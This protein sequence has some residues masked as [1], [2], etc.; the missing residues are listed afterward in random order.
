MS[1][2]RSIR[3]I[4]RLVK[5]HGETRTLREA[6][7]CSDIL[8]EFLN[9]KQVS[10]ITAFAM[11]DDIMVDIDSSSL[12]EEKKAQ[13]K[14]SIVLKSEVAQ[15]MGNGSF[16]K[17]LA[18][19][20]NIDTL[21][22]FCSKN[23]FF[24]AGEATQVNKIKDLD[25][26]KGHL[27]PA[28]AY[29]TV[30]GVFPDIET[31]VVQADLARMINSIVSVKRVTNNHTWISVCLGNKEEAR[32]LIQKG[33]VWYLGRKCNVFMPSV[34][35]TH[36][37]KCLKQGHKATE[38]K[39]ALICVRCLCAGHKQVDCIADVTCKSCGEAH[40]TKSL[41]CK[42]PTHA[43]IAKP[44]GARP[45]PIERKQENMPRAVE[46]KGTDSASST[47]WA[48]VVAG[49][50]TRNTSSSSSLSAVS[51]RPA[52]E[53]SPA[54]ASVSAHAHA[55]SHSCS[56]TCAG[57][58]AINGD[59]SAQ[60]VKFKAQSEEI[61]MLKRLVKSLQNQVEALT[62]ELRRPK[63]KRT[64]TRTSSSVTATAAA[65][66]ATTAAADVV[67]AAAVHVA[68][69]VTTTSP[70]DAAVASVTPRAKPSAVANKPPADRALFTASARKR[71]NSKRAAADI[72]T[73]EEPAAASPVAMSSL[74]MLAVT[75]LT[76]SPKQRLT[77]S[78]KA[79]PS[80]PKPTGGNVD[81]VRVE[82]RGDEPVSMVLVGDE[83][84]AHISSQDTEIDTPQS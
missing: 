45:H 59:V 79:T 49:K 72:S 14:L 3:E 4:Y 8:N 13:G 16:R 53:S 28:V 15:G 30:K 64:T 82:T 5:F 9:L 25:F 55:P 56:C 41:L 29:I 54:V 17:K 51:A 44:V 74:A 57:A 7:T 69:A 48:A 27:A 39:S 42:R 36:C 70:A 62:L 6:S 50:P 32:L 33:D 37:F 80:T 20:T 63:P 66:T 19:F 26:I 21:K 22:I 12:E 18:Q 58:R 84:E 81:A 78:R 71:A 52:S 34:R 73:Q 61:T 76:P 47:S 23:H 60:E 11:S 2:T 38:C 75:P 43:A 10:E 65:A 31:E 40:A 67:V 35:P 77:K 83:R 68:A 24:I 1:Q 46:V